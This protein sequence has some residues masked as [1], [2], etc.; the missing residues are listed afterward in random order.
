MNWNFGTEAITFSIDQYT[1]G[2]TAVEAW[3]EDG[4]YATISVNMPD[5][6]LL[7]KGQFFL[8]DWSENAPLAQA[9]IAEGIIE[10]VNPPMTTQ[11]GFITATAYQFSELGKQ[12]CDTQS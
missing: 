5:T 12:Y 8:K 2:G 11:S 9:M 3:C 6:H 4:P 1:D 7:S 10:P